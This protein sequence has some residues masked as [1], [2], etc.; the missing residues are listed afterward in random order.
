MVSKKGKTRI[1]VA[2]SNPAKLKAVEEAFG[3]FFGEIEIVGQKVDSG[4]SDSPLSQEETIKGAKNRIKNLKLNKDLDFKVSIEAGTDR[5]EDVRYLFT[6]VMIE[7]NGEVLFGRS[8]SYPLPSKVSVML[9]KGAHLSDIA[10][11]MSGEE[12]I[13]SKGGFVEYL[14]KGTIDRSA[15]TKDAVICALFPIINEGIYK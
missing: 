14:S 8:I 6:F 15:L 9:E 10:A 11:K 1:L 2:S 3:E 4:V 12:D 7:T 13:R 5:I